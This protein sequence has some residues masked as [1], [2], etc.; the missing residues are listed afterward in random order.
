M[1]PFI[2]GVVEATVATFSL[3]GPVVEIGAYQVEG[4][5]ALIDLRRLFRGT[6]YLGIDMRPGPGV[7]RVEN[8][9]RMTLA[10][11]S[12]GTVLALST[13]EHVR[14]F[15]LG[16]EEIKRIVR[17]DGVLVISTPFYFHIHNHP[18]DYWRFTPE[19]LDSLLEDQF[20]Q[21][22]LGQQGP[23]KRPANTWIIAFGRDYP[24]IS[25]EQ[26]C[27]Y[28]SA[29]SRLARSPREVSRTL[30]YRVARLL[31]GRGPFSAHLDRDRFT[32]ELRR[33]SK[34]AEQAA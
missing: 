14:R 21:R 22:I 11:R 31:C 5:E 30:R 26:V 12:V 1:T 13:F 10:S 19:A 4:Q 9:E 18:S 15:W 34:V 25:G 16:V 17:P 28:Q 3:P 33:G 20:P 32:I 23:S 2:R 7:D 29:I 27:Q 24:K 8:V 6:S